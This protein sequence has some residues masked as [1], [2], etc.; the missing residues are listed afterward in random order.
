MKEIIRQG[1]LDAASFFYQ[2]RVP[3]PRQADQHH[4]GYF[5]VSRFEKTGTGLLCFA[6]PVRFSSFCCTCSD[7]KAICWDGGRDW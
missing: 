6:G 2:I 4:I 1:R 7:V 3:H 5:V